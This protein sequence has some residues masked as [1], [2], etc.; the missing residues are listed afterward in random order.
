MWSTDRDPLHSSSKDDDM[1][2]LKRKAKASTDWGVQVILCEV[3]I[4]WSFTRFQLAYGMLGR[5]DVHAKQFG[6][7]PG[8]THE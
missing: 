3:D 1:L 2:E 4:F 8:H 5:C 7:M 6:D